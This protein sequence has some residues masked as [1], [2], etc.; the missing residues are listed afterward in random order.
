MPYELP[1]FTNNTGIE[2]ILQYGSNQVPFLAP[3]ILFMIYIVILVGGYFAQER[4]VGAG[5]FLMWASIS[6]L[7]T[8]TGAFILYLYDNVVSIQ[9]VLI[10]VIITIISAFAFLIS[11][12]D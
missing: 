8:T 9:V 1:N 11:S 10:C 12:R 7:I 5:N 6:G 3:A 4:R 2:E